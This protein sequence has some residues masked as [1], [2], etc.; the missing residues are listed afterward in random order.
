MTLT[1]LKEILGILQGFVVPILGY[2]I[3]LLID[4]RDHLSRLNGRVGTCEDLREAHVQSDKEKHDNCEERL[5]GVEML[6]MRRRA[7]E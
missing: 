5:Q 6:L 2:G 4:I 1:E 7:G 3:W